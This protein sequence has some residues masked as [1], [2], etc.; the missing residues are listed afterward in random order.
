MLYPDA[1]AEDVVSSMDKTGSRLLVV[2]DK[3]LSNYEINLPKTF[4]HTIILLNVADQMSAIPRLL[5]RKKAAYRQ[6][7]SALHTITWCEF[8]SGG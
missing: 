6:K 1:S 8:I 4:S 7:N 5:A 3:L 2:V